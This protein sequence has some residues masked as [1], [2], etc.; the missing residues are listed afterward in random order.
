MDR[1]LL[2]FIAMFPDIQERELEFGPRDDEECFYCFAY[3]LRL[4]TI[5]SVA[6]DSVDYVMEDLA[7][8]LLGYRD[9]PREVYLLYIDK[10]GGEEA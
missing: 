4:L 10:V 9:T 8:S 2:G 5:Q 6:L 7:T 3:T 1:R